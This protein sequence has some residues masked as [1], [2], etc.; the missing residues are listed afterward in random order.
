LASFSACQIPFRQSPSQTDNEIRRGGNHG[1]AS[2]KEK[3]IVSEFNR[4]VAIKVLP[5]AFAKDAQYIARIE[6][7]PPL[8]AVLNHP[9]ARIS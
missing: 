7:E 4:E 8:L 1:D 9:D 5:A 6:R 2:E 3:D